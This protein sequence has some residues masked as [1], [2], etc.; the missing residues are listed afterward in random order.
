ME[1]GDTKSM[2]Y[3]TIRPDL[4]ADWADTFIRRVILNVT[5]TGG[6]LAFACVAIDDVQGDIATALKAPRGKGVS[7]TGARTPLD[8]NVDQ[9]CRILLVLEDGLNWQ[10]RQDGDAVTAKDDFAGSYGGLVHILADGG[11]AQG[12]TGPGAGCKAVSFAA[13]A[14]PTGAG[15]YSHGFNFHVDI[16]QNDGILP[17]VIDPD[18]QHPGGLKPGGG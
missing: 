17:L 8:L 15:N 5:I 11:L 10:F 6:N 12:G 18:I 1:A 3:F 2:S 4:P 16:V 7:G 9:P 14:P 13:V